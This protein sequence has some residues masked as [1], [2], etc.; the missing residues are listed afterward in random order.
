MPGI[1]IIDRINVYKSIQINK[2]RMRRLAMD[3][4]FD[5]ALT[6]ILSSELQLYGMHFISQLVPG[7][8]M[9]CIFCFNLLM[10]S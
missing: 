2:M 6:C 9:D 1:I 8:R 5:F 3:L 4:H 10:E 7:Q